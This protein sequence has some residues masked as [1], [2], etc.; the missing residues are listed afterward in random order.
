MEQTIEPYQFV[1]LSRVSKHL[2]NTYKTVN[3][4]QTIAA[5]QAMT[6]DTIDQLFDPIP[7]E[8]K[9]LSLQLMDKK[10]TFKQLEFALETVKNYVIDFEIPSEKQIQKL[11]K[12][13]KKMTY[14][15]WEQLDTKEAT[16]VGW[17]DIATQRKFLIAYLDGNLT[18]V[19]GIQSATTIK[20]MCA[21]CQHTDQVS[22]FLAK[23]KSAGD[24]TYTKQGNYICMDSAKC[25]QNVGN[26]YNLAHF[27]KTVKEK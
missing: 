15:N 14:P 16:Y 3:D 9:H 5:I 25:N 13:V 24:G 20:N 8:I 12:K 17:H 2:I 11:F 21:I 6:L 7:H 1:T 18:G 4:P 19:S 26:K 23:T 22:L 10:M 27:F